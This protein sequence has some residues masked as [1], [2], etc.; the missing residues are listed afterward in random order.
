[1]LSAQFIRENADRVRS[2]VAARGADAPI[3]DI[4]TLDQIFIGDV[5]LT[6]KN[7][8]ASFVFLTVL[9]AKFF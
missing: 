3:D 9:F 1:M 7:L 4:L 6:F 8:S 5:Q 2:D